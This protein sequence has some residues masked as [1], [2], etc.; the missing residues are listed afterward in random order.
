MA[1]DPTYWDIDYAKFKKHKWVEFYG[2][3]KEAILT[4]MP[5]PRGKSV[6]LRMHVNINH[7]GEKA[8]RRSR[9][10]FFIFMK[11]ALIQGMSNKQPTIEISVFGAE[12]MVIKHGME[13]LC[14]IRYKFRMMGIPIKGPSYI[15]GDNMS[16]IN[17][18]HQLESTI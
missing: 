12:F 15:Y 16:V 11:L 17:N 3:V 13:T 7:A 2:N 6:D 5:E 8:T 9:T 1:L 14:G 18:T 10:G 4:D